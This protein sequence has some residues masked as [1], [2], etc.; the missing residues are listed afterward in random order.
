MPVNDIDYKSIQISQDLLMV[1]DLFQCQYILCIQFTHV[2]INSH[3]GWFFNLKLDTLVI[4]IM[5]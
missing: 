2:Y 5:L 1:Y 3:L 4:F